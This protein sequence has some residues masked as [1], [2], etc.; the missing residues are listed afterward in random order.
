MKS[1]SITSVN[2]IPRHSGVYS[3]TPDRFFRRTV[4]ILVALLTSLCSVGAWQTF[5]KRKVAAPIVATAP[6]IDYGP[7]IEAQAKEI[8]QLREDVKTLRLALLRPVKVSV[9][10]QEYPSSDLLPPPDA[11]EAPNG[12]AGNK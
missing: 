5:N 6:A 12:G 4:Y 10:T 9:S 7:S 2:P 3:K 8:E 1:I 11:I